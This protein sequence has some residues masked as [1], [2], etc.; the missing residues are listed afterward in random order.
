MNE[1]PRLVLRRNEIVPA[2]GRRVDWLEPQNLVGE[3]VANVMR[4]EIAATP[5]GQAVSIKNASFAATGFLVMEDGRR[6]PGWVAVFEIFF[7]ENIVAYVGTYHGLT[8][9]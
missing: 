9:V 1:P 3:R 4:T 8:H 7:P 2:A 5:R 6:F